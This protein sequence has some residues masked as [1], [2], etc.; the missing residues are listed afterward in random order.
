MYVGLKR[1]MKQ[2]MKA[3][4]NYRFIIIIGEAGSGKICFGFELMFQMQKKIQNFIVLVFIDSSQWN[5]LDFK[6]EY[7]FFFDDLLGKLNVNDLVFYGWSMVFDLMY[8][9]LFNNYVIIIFVLRNCIWYL[10]KDRLVDYTLFRLLYLFN[11][12]V[13]FLGDFGMIF[14]EKL[15]MLKRFC[16]CNNVIVCNIFYE[17]EMLFECL[18]N[19]FLCIC[20]E[21]FRIIVNIDILCG[22]LF[23]CE[24]FFFQKKFL[25]QGLSFFYV[26]F[27]SSY[28]K[29]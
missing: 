20:Q 10:M 28:F 15:E 12:L 19:G 14:R 6:K 4:E 8:K 5:K 2:S 18:N 24:E 22:F 21:F 23:L 26:Y 16:R 3:F 13:D 11:L 9:K 17:E 25:K 27:V 7:I 1:V 29:G